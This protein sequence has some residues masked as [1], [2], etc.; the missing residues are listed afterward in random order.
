M[1]FVLEGG[2]S[3][4]AFSPAQSVQLRTGILTSGSICLPRL[5]IHDDGAVLQRCLNSDINAAFVPGYS[6][7]PV[8]E[9]HRVP[10]YAQT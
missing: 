6:G 3:D 1:P 10:F 9:L 7:G 2:F 5:P 4:R 8:P